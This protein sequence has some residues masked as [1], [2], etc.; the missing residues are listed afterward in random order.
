MFVLFVSMV[1]SRQ[2]NRRDGSNVFRDSM[3][4]QFTIKHGHSILDEVLFYEFMSFSIE[5]NKQNLDEFIR[6]NYEPAF[7]GFTDEQF[8]KLLDRWI[9]GML[10]RG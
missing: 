7:S 9:F 2:N 10:A 4:A 1:S 6:E 5:F 8:D 3:V